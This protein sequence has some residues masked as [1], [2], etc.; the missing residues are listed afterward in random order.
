MKNL[1]IRKIGPGLHYVQEDHPLE[2]AE[3]VRD[4]R[5]RN[6]VRGS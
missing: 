1:E 5:R 4:W 2:I 3:A 6:V